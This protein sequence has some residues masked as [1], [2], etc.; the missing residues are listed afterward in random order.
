[1][2]HDVLRGTSCSQFK[3]LVH[4]FKEE[5][6][7]ALARL[8]LLLQEHSPQRASARETATVLSA[9]ISWR[10]KEGLSRKLIGDKE[11]EKTTVSTTLKQLEKVLHTNGLFLLLGGWGKEGSGGWKSQLLLGDSL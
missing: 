6:P 1:M 3:M 9:V 2:S 8:R 11:K 4:R 10:V 7:S 5:A